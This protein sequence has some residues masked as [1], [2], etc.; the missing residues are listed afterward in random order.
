MFTQCSVDDDGDYMQAVA[1]HKQYAKAMR[2]LG[3]KGV[4]LVVLPHDRRS[5]GT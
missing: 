3:A 4:Q 2:A 5:G 1:A